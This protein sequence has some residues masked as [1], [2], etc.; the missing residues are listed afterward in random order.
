MVMNRWRAAPIHLALSAVV[1]ATIFA[2]AYLVWYPGAM[3][4]A[5]GGRDLF[6]LIAGVDVTLGP[7]VTL[8]IYVPGKRGLKMDLAIIAV[9]QLSALA[10]GTHVLFEAR[11]VWIV[12]VKDRFEIARANQIADA[13]R[14]KA[15]P[16]F[17]AMS[18]TGPRLAGARLPTDPDERFNLSISAAAG[19]DVQTYPQYLVPY[20]QSRPEVISHARPIAKLRDYNPDPGAKIAALPA[21][22]RLPESRLGFLPMRAGKQD[23]TVIVDMSNG[24]YLGTVGLKP[25]QY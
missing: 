21:R 2:I 3:Y 12:F 10:Y 25:W 5:A 17:Y 14:A 20:D 13:E 11:P 15:K 6:L 1:A 24:E 7:L 18:V 16:P 19:L 4:D 8:I 22:F 9:V 23:L